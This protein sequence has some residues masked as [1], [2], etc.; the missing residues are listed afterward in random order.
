MRKGSKCTEA[1]RRKMSRSRTGHKVSAETRKK[2]S[3][4]NT[5]KT[6]SKE[7]RKKI[8]DVQRG[9]KASA[10]T[11]KRMSVA[12]RRAFR[13]KHRTALATGIR[14]SFEYRQWRSDVFTRDDF[15]CRECDRRGGDME[16]HHLKPFATIL[17][18]N[19]I[20]TREDAIRCAELWNINNGKTLC[21]ACHRK[22]KG[23]AGRMK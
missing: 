10:A 18:D 1:T 9:R 23:W 12:L 8:G 20:K 22:T 6:Y 15:T 14:Q 3:K 11:K 13:G 21:I 19:N 16:A 17:R 2:L 7:T 4:A 5:G